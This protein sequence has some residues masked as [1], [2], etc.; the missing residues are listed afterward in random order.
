MRW[1]CSVCGEEHEGLPLDRAYDSPTYWDGPRNR[2]DW[3][4]QD[5]CTWT[6]DAGERAYFIRGVLHVPVP[7]LDD[8][9]RYGVWTSL[10]EKSFERV[11][12]LWDEPAR[13]EEEPYFGW[14][15]NSLPN[16]PETL[17]L[18]SDVVTADLEL[19]P[20]ILLHDGDHPLV[21]EQRVGIT[22]ERLLEIVGPGLHEVAVDR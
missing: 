2:D 11:L 6:D 17:R 19:R 1:R 15:M 14:L 3:L 5:L 16:Y 10:S 21:R 18:P 20:N 22:L 7:E 12:E 4:T 13:M 8:S 9:L